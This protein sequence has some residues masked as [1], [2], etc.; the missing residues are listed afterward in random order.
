MPPG[1]EKFHSLCPIHGKPMDLISV[2]S[3][4]RTC[5]SCALFG[6]TKGHDVRPEHDVMDE[7]NLRS[8][9]LTELYTMMETSFA[10]KP[11]EL[12][13]N[14]LNINYKKKDQELKK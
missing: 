6:A 14:Q 8:E 5:S 9:C 13:V 3:R 1:A 4:E 7:I 11:N 12:E 10:E 2:T